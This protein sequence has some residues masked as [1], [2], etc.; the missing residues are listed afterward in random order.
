MLEGLSEFIKCDSFKVGI[1]TV[2]FI[3]ALAFTLDE[4]YAKAADVEKVNG[5]LAQQIDQSSRNLRRQML[6]DKIFELDVRKDQSKIHQLTPVDQALRDRYQQ[7]LNDLNS[8]E[9]QLR[10]QQ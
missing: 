7:Q 10:S 2:V 9:L 1:G 4:R 3:I 5:Q 8:R 6:E